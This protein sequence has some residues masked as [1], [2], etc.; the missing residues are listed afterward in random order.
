VTNRHY[1]TAQSHCKKTPQSVDHPTPNALP[2]DVEEMRVHNLSESQ[3]TPAIVPS[4]LRI[5]SSVGAQRERGEKEHMPIIK[6]ENYQ[7]RDR[8]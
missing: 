1:N 6:A 5:V 4:L 8:Y 7:R 2:F 3:N